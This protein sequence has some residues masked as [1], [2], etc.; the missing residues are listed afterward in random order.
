MTHP[1]AGNL[2]ALSDKDLYDKFHA[3]QSKYW[4]ASNKSVKSQIEMLLEDYH[5]EIENRKGKENKELDD[6]IKVV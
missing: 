1:L 6:L 3:L 4:Y 5:L 2:S